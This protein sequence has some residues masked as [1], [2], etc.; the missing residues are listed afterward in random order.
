MPSFETVEEIVPSDQSTCVEIFR[1]GS[2]PSEGELRKR[3]V[4]NHFIFQS[5]KRRS[6]ITG[7]ARRGRQGRRQN[8]GS[9]GFAN[10]LF[11]VFA[12]NAGNV[13]RGLGLGRNVGWLV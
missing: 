6:R 8:V 9:E 2:R 10:P 13:D 12:G 7:K 4:P 1:L 3:G 5:S 11:S